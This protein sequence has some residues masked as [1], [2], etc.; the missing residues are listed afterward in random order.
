MIKV[1][2]NMGFPKGRGDGDGGEKCCLLGGVNYE[3]LWVTLQMS[4]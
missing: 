1:E 4:V 3:V 2:G